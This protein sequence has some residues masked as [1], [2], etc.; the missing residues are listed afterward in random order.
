MK[1]RFI[2]WDSKPLQSWAEENA[3]GEF[4]ALNGSQAHYVVAGA[5]SPV[6]LIH[7]FFF[8]ST[9]WL[10]NIEALAQSHR[11][12]AIDLWGFG[13][14]ARDMGMPSYDLYSSQ[15][16][17][18][19][20]SI[21]VEKASLVG[22][23]LG[24]GVAVRFCVQNPA[25]VEKLVLVDTAGMPN[26]EP[27]S[28]RM[29]SLPGIG[30]LLLKLPSNIVRKK[31]LHDFFLFDAMGLSHDLYERLVKFQKIKGTNFAMLGVMRLG[32]ADK[33]LESIQQLA[34]FDVPIQ[35]IW[36]KHDKAISQQL[37]YKLH[38]RLP[39]SVFSVIDHA[40][41]VPNLEQPTIFNSQVLNFLD[42]DGFS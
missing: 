25:R 22:Q 2:N 42:E 10:H 13:Y 38:Q 30:E 40:A 8:D 36:G 29:F 31:M 1:K 33:L 3:A 24:G 18:F 17:A 27:L 19:I 23:S 28:S 37:G 20:D 26:P 39:H 34:E 4:I 41:H 7:G 16:L 32:F 5:G 6:I 11:A 14:S 12:Y 15:I 21:G 35:L 9:L